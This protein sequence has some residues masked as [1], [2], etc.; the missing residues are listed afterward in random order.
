MVQRLNPSWRNA[1]VSIPVLAAGPALIVLA[2]QVASATGIYAGLALSVYALRNVFLI[3]CGTT[4]LWPDGIENRL[5][6]ATASVPWEQVER[7]I[8]VPTVFG[9]F[10]QIEVAEGSRVT[11]AA[12]RSGLLARAKDFDRDLRLIQQAPG[13]GRA[14]LRLERSALTGQP[15]FQALLLVVILGAVIFALSHTGP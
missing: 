2:V 14:R 7:L 11:L 15:S 9:R 13:G 8:V 10:L 6:G 1:L 5:V 3:Q 4:A 12:P